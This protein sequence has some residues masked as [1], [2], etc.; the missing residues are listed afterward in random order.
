MKKRDIKDA[1]SWQVGWEDENIPA[2]GLEFFDEEDDAL[3]YGESLE[4]KGETGICLTKLVVAFSRP[5]DVPN[6]VFLWENG[7]P[8][9]TEDALIIFPVGYWKLVDGNWEYL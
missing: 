4:K 9:E 5:A 8:E 3:E 6:D 1:V 7:Y 2:F